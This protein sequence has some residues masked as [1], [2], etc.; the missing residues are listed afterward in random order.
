MTANFSPP[1]SKSNK[2]KHAPKS[3]LNLGHYRKAKKESFEGSEFFDLE[4]TITND[5][6]PNC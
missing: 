2:P 6:G 5:Y 1:D 4:P 3:K